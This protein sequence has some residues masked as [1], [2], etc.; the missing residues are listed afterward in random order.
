MLAEV[1]RRQ[2]RIVRQGGPFVQGLT[3]NGVRRPISARPL[4][5]ARVAALCAGL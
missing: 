1:Q 4:C 3:K 2:W 5:C